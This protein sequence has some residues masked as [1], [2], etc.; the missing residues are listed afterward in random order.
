[1][2]NLFFLSSKALYDWHDLLLCC[3]YCFVLMKKQ[4]LFTPF[5]YCQPITE[6]QKNLA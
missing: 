3:I 6:S 4:K 1:M 2:I 5:N